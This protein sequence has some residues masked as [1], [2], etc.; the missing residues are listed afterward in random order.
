MDHCVLKT[1]WPNFKPMILAGFLAGANT[2]ETRG[3][4]G[5]NSFPL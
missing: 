3:W 2:P 1:A 5:H 4:L